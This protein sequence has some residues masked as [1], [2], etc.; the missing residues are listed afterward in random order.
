MVYAS[1]S[2]ALGEAAH[3]V[4]VEVHGKGQ[5]GQV[6]AQ[7]G[8]GG[9]AGAGKGCGAGGGGGQ[10]GAGD[11]EGEVGAAQPEEDGAPCEVE[12]KL[13]GKEAK[14][15]VV[16][17]DAAP[18]AQVESEG[19]DHRCVERG[20][21]DAEDPRRWGQG[22]LGQ[23]GV[24]VH[25]RRFNQREG[26]ENSINARLLLGRVVPEES[27]AGVRKEALMVVFGQAKG[28]KGVGRRGSTSSGHRGGGLVE[29]LESWGGA[30][31]E[32][33]EG[34]RVRTRAGPGKEEHD[35]DQVK[36]GV[37][38][39]KGVVVRVGEVGP[40]ELGVDHVVE[41]VD[42]RGPWGQAAQHVGPGRGASA[43]QEADDGHGKVPSLAL[44]GRCGAAQ[45]LG[46]VEEA[47]DLGAPDVVRDRHYVPYESLAGEDK[48]NGSDFIGV[49][50]RVSGAGSV[51]AADDAAQAGQGGVEVG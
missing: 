25:N 4:G 10:E 6:G 38:G 47:P 44:A 32:V 23:G 19:G 50:G 14:P 34:H 30:G 51:E 33:D 1:R 27:Q 28:G 49:G 11:D 18:G 20:P 13:C 31:C 3:N 46:V 21:D 39:R 5:P 12:G 36:G 29:A 15:G 2:V 26:D 7:E 37:F 17:S 48:L 24:I 22:R 45:G 41:V 43:G 35:D 40:P 16:P 9:G 8:G 42:G